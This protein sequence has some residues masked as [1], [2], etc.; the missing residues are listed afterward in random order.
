[1]AVRINQFGVPEGDH[2]RDQIAAPNGGSARG[3]LADLSRCRRSGHHG[4]ARRDSDR[5]LDIYAGY[6]VPGTR[7]HAALSVALSA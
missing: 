3:Y 4:R 7:A 2:L 1:M 6:R 5:A